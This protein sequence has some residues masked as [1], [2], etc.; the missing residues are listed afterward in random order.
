[1]QI[2]ISHFMLKLYLH[3]NYSSLWTDSNKRGEMKSKETRDK[4]REQ[5]E[6]EEIERETNKKRRRKY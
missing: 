5:I 6:R 1:M 2:A 4:E 3:L